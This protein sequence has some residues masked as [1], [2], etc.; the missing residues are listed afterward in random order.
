MLIQNNYVN[1]QIK[2]YKYFY[3]LKINK[4]FC[5]CAIT[6][7]KRLTSQSERVTSR[8]NK[9]TNLVWS[10]KQIALLVLLLLYGGVILLIILC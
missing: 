6:K 3:F 5:I 2:H 4:K 8:F 1:L 10:V 9:Q 7:L